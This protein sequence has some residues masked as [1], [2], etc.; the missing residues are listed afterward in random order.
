MRSTLYLSMASLCPHLSWGPCCLVLQEQQR[1]GTAMSVT[2]PAG[3]GA[4]RLSLKTWPV[5]HRPNRL[6]FA[7]VQME[8]EGGEVICSGR[9][10]QKWWSRVGMGV[11]E[12]TWDGIPT[13]HFLTGKQ[14]I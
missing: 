3:P 13:N 8:A 6:H 4:Q 5:S 9:T 2:H 10:A 14:M 11:G 12:Q 1:N 7:D